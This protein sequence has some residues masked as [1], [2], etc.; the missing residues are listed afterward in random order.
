MEGGDAS[1]SAHGAESAGCRGR[2]AARHQGANRGQRR[3]RQRAAVVVQTAVRR[4]LARHR[5]GRLRMLT[6]HRRARAVV[7]LQCAARVWRAQEEVFYLTSFPGC[8]VFRGEDGRWEVVRPPVR[9]GAPPLPSEVRE[10]G[11]LF[12]SVDGW[13]RP[14]R[15]EDFEPDEETPW[16]TPPPRGFT[17]EL[18]RR[19]AER[20]AADDGD[21]SGDT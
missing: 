10:L 16:A 3:A 9:D 13:V 21:A 15:A 12:V 6:V 5:D 1:P 19:A 18:R 11:F 20:D 4:L 8:T 17:D 2:R 14:L 7:V